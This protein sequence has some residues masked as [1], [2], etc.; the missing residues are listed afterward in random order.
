LRQELKVRERRELPDVENKKN[1][2]LTKSHDRLI[3]F[4]ADSSVSGMYML[5]AHD[6]C[7]G[8]VEKWATGSVEILMT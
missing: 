2:D 4:D 3:R 1:I 5:S 7:C 8:V 6:A